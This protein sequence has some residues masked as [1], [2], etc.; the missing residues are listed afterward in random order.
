MNAPGDPGSHAVPVSF[1]PYVPMTFGQAL[2]RVVK[3]VKAHMKVFFAI[4]SLPSAVY[5]GCLAVIV[6][7]LLMIV[8]PWHKI[9]PARL[10]PHL[11]LEWVLFFALVLVAELAMLF[12]YALC[13]P[14]ASYAALQADAGVTVTFREAYA[15]AWQKLGRYLWLLFLKSLVVSGPILIFAIFIV[16]GTVTMA[17]R[18]NGHADPSAAFAM[19]PL[20]ILLYTFA[21]IYTVFALIWLAFSYPACIAENL[22]A[23]ASIER[24]VRLT[25][26]ARLRIFLLAAVIYAILYA[27]SLVLECIL[28]LVGGVIAIAGFALHLAMNPWGYIGIG[29]A[30]IFLFILIFFSVAISTAGYSTA[31]AVL[32]RNQRHCTEGNA[33]AGTLAPSQ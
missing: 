29:I 7:W 33:P 23:A 24:S 3:L 1:P 13:Q 19:F 5:A 18:S 20:L 17:F 25:K 8:Q 15:K 11:G 2:D 14:A 16:V 10:T 27:A 31:F 4:A 12:T 21:G 22:T 9:D 32:Y 6:A 26:G 30:A 28:G